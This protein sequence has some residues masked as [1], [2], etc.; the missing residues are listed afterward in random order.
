MKQGTKEGYKN[1]GVSSEGAANA[2]E[3][4]DDETP[5]HP[6]VFDQHPIQSPLLAVIQETNVI[7]ADEVPGPDVPRCVVDGCG[8][9][10]TTE[11]DGVCGYHVA[12][13]YRRSRRA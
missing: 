11:F 6:G 5:A 1:T 12:T 4:L 9:P 13:G 2:R 10:G 3:A 7:D 8:R